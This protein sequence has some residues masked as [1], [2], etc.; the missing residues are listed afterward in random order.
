MLFA[1]MIIL[2]EYRIYFVLLYQL[3][4]LLEMSRMVNF[5]GF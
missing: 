2:H 1:L 3:I 5:D 4:D